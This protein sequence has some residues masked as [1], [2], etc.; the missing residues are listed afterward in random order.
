M[1]TADLMFARPSP[2]IPRG[3][4]AG[5]TPPGRKAAFPAN[6][7]QGLGLGP[8]L[9]S[10]SRLPRLSS[11]GMDEMTAKVPSVP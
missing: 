8:F 6:V 7:L 4:S 10:G 1:G 5:A 11:R 9:R 3:T 2:P